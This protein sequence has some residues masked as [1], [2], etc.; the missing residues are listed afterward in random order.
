M[1]GIFGGGDVPLSGTDPIQQWGNYSGNQIND[2]WRGAQG[3]MSGTDPI[4]PWGGYTG[5]QI[6]NAW[7]QAQQ[8]PSLWDKLTKAVGDTKPEDLK[9]AQDFLK[10]P[11]AP[12]LSPAAAPSMRERASMNPYHNIYSRLSLDPKTALKMLMGNLG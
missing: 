2:A 5:N 10:P 9:K 7:Q 11:A 12:P 6:G 8:E 4:A 3:G 1:A